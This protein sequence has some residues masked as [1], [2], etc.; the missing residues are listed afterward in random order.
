[1]DTMK[2]TTLAA[3]A[4]LTMSASLATAGNLDTLVVEEVPIVEAPAGGSIGSGVGLA[5]L[6]LGIIAVAVATSD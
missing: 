3:A 1:M 6:A 5:L 2:F 4:A